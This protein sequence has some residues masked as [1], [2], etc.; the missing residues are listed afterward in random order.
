MENTKENVRGSSGT[1][2]GHSSEAAPNPVGCVQKAVGCAT[3][4]IALIR[5]TALM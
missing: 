3:R 2:P 5:A 4:K 1:I